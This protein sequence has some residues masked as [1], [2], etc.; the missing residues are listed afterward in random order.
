MILQVRLTNRSYLK[1]PIIELL[2]GQGEEQTLLTAHQA[3]LTKSPF[4]ADAVA[5][6]SKEAT[7]SSIQNSLGYGK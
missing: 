4:F 3:L 6:F 2:V 1:S 5:Q 7:V